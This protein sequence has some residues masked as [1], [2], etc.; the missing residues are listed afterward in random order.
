MHFWNHNLLTLW[1]RLVRLIPLH[2][3]V[4]L[5]FLLVFAKQSWRIL[6]NLNF[7]GHLRYT[8]LFANFVFVRVHIFYVDHFINLF[9]GFSL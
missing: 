3:N 2:T 8:H 4:L 7:V 1:L 5:V 6:F 9:F